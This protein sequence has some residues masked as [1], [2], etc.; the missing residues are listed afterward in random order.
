MNDGFTGGMMIAVAEART[1]CKGEPDIAERIKKAMKVCRNHWM[2][3]NETNQFRS[4]L[5]AAMLESEDEAEKDRIGRSSRAIAKLNAMLNALQAGVPV[6]IEA[7]SAEKRDADL[8]P[9]MDL[10]HDRQKAC[11]PVE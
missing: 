9:L 10:W 7:M 4:A 6:D 2:E 3:T 5:A 8:L 11:D 1:A